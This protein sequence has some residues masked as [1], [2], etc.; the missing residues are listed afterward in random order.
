MLSLYAISLVMPLLFVTVAI[1]Q[2]PP[3]MLEMHL[4]DDLD[5]PL[6]LCNDGSRAKYYVRSCPRPAAECAK[7]GPPRWVVVF[8]NGG[9]ADQ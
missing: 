5:D 2:L 1:A 6:A 3:S 7:A 9:I 8:E 4:R